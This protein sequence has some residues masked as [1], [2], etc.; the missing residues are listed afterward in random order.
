[1]P[2]IIVNYTQPLQGTDL[3]NFVQFM[4][5]VPQNKLG[6]GYLPQGTHKQV[7]SDIHFEFIQDTLYK[8]EMEGTYQCYFIG[9]RN[10]YAGPT[11]TELS[12]GGFGV[13]YDLTQ[14]V[15]VSNLAF[16]QNMQPLVLK[17]QIHCHCT[18]THLKHEQSYSI[19]HPIAQ[20]IQ[21][22]QTLTQIP[23][24]NAQL[25]YYDEQNTRSYTIMKKLP[26]KDLFS[27]LYEDNRVFTLQE[28]MH[29]TLNLLDAV[30]VQVTQLGFFHGDLKIENLMLGPDLQIN[31]CDYANASQKY[32]PT[33]KLSTYGTI[34]NMPPELFECYN[35]HLLSVPTEEQDVFAIGI[36]LWELWGEQ[37]LQHLYPEQYSAYLQYLQG[38]ML[39]QVATGNCFLNLPEEY[40][41]EEP[42]QHEISRL[43]L[44]ML[45]PSPAKRI[46]FQTAI[47]TARRIFAPYLA[48]APTAER[49]EAE[50]SAQP[51]AAASASLLG[52]FKTTKSDAMQPEDPYGSDWSL[53]S[54]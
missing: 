6:C 32:E 34:K 26:G 45:D 23:H 40:R 2:R 46:N 35:N 39:Q 24:L 4:N 43:L 19:H 14:I 21:E 52:L 51:A 29:L 20:G 3:S 8:K 53:A 38:A 7:G 33:P 49:P 1:M 31:V 27:V 5:A 44:A 15:S 48:H 50:T 11:L 37:I 28:R 16:K 47:E 36:V 25:F 13:V 42:L 54:S 18:D 10:S 30:S 22:Y 12:Q 17:E 41:P 9:A